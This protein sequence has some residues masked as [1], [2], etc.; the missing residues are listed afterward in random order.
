MSHEIRT[1]MNAIIG[2]T[3]LVLDTELAPRQRDYLGRIEAASK[4]LLG[5]LNAILDYSKIESGTLQIE[6]LPFSLEQ[7]LHI[8]RDLFSARAE[9]KGLSFDVVAAADCP[10]R[11]W[12]IP[13]GS[14]RCWPTWSATPSSSPSAATCD[15]GF[16]RMGASG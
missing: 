16:A 14:G 5:V 12:A 11:S 15:S 6:T 3:Q 1:P 7:V 9:E 10:T 8:V 2:L 4:A 13:C